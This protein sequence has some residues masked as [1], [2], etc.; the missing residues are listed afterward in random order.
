MPYTVRESA[1]PGTRA[2]A[3]PQVASTPRTESFTDE[4]WR[5]NGQA[6]DT[7]VESIGG[8]AE[9]TTLLTINEEIPEVERVVR[10][11]LDPRYERMALK[12]LCAM[13]GLTVADLFLA[14]RKAMI[15]RSHLEATRIIAARLPP[16]V[17]DVMQRALPTRHPCPTCENRDGRREQC[18]T[19]EGAGVVL[20]EPSLDRQKLALELGQ[21]TER[22]GGGGFVIQTSAVAAA[23]SATAQAAVGSDE[24]GSLELLQQAVGDL[25]SQSRRKERR[26][27]T[28]AA[29][30]AEAAETTVVDVTPTSVEGAE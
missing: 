19:C 4:E 15:A 8:R 12:R 28:A 23:A 17:E 14:Y 1:P 20:Q 7:F 29:E 5:L 21:L 11:L 22:K 25:L 18:P 26:A 30:A 3:A 13:A 24:P 6:V 16:I 9:L 2:L 10:L 27:Q